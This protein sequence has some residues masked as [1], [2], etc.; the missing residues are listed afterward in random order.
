M[1]FTTLGYFNTL[2]WNI[3]HR[4]SIGCAKNLSI[5]LGNLTKLVEAKDRTRL[6]Q[7]FRICD[8]NDFSHAQDAATFYEI[9]FLWIGNYIDTRQ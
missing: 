6:T 7:L 9:A 2:S 5:A 8:D 3:F 4:G 1:L